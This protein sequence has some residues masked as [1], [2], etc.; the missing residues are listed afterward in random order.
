MKASKVEKCPKKAQLLGWSSGKRPNEEDV[1][2]ILL[3]FEKQIYVDFG[4]QE[5]IVE[6]SD[7][8]EKTTPR[9]LI[10]AAAKVL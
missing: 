4:E 6:L 7:I 1:Y 2:A 3:K 9:K 8:P 5:G 10:S